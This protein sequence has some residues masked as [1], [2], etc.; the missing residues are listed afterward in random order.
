MDNAAVIAELLSA[1]S[2]DDEA[3]CIFLKMEG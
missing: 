3:K 1:V 2:A